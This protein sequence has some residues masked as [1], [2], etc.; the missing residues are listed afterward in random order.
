MENPDDDVTLTR[1]L[2]TTSILGLLKGSEI[3]YILTKNVVENPDGDVTRAHVLKL[4][5]V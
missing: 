4:R 1:V 5:T 3:L 2:K